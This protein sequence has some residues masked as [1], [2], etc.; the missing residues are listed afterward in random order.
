MTLTKHVQNSDQSR[1]LIG[2]RLGL[3]IIIVLVS[4]IMFWFLVLLISDIDNVIWNND[5][6]LPPNCYSINGK[7]I[8]PPKS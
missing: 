3:A 1:W 8:C 6:Y 2:R 5:N 7:Q 4:G